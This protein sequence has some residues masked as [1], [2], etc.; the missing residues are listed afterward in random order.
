MKTKLIYE[1]GVH[2]GW[3]PNNQKWWFD[4]NH[5]DSFELFDLDGLYSKEYFDV[6]HVNQSAVNNYYNYVNEYYTKITG[7]KLKSVFEAGCAG[8]WFTKKFL[9]NQIDIIAIEGSKCGFDA[10]IQKGVNIENIILHDL[11]NEINLNRKFDIVCCTEVAEHIE[12]PFSSQLI[13]TLVTHS[14]LIWFSF[15]EPGTNEAH[16]HHSNEQPEKFWVNLFDFYDYDYI[17]IPENVI[18]SVEHRGSHLFYNKQVYGKLD[19]I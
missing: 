7:K 10:S 2:V 1:N 6:D 5:P 12:T 19:L 4:V 3:I 9:D 16:Y 8:G 17:K 15:E 11:R 18:Q 13:K 14:D